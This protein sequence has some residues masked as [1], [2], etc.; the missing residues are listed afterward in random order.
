MSTSQERF[1]EQFHQLL[2]GSDKENEGSQDETA[3]G[4]QLQD[5]DPDFES[6]S[7]D[8]HEMSWSTT[9][10]TQDRWIFTGEYGPAAH[11]FSC[12]HPVVFYNL[13]LDAGMMELEISETNRYGQRRAEKFGS[14]LK[15]RNEEILNLPSDENRQTTT[16]A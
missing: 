1:E 11:I 10:S 5:K 9:T 2:I 7:G 15:G 12:S 14:D 6:E 4:S 8:E 13:F 16:T 3:D